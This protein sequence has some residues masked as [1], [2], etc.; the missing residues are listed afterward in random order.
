MGE[1]CTNGNCDRRGAYL[2]A[3]TNLLISDL[4]YMAGAWA[5]G[6]EARSGLMA[7]TAAGI[8]AIL[9]GMGSLSF[10]ETAGER[11]RLGGML[12]DPE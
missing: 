6:G 4:E 3:A 1:A 8:S 10:G 11:M 12:N 7:A 2:T 5:D 9:T